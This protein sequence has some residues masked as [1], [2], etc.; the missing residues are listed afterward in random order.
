MKNRYSKQFIIKKRFACL[1]LAAGI[2]GCAA[3]GIDEAALPVF[4][5]VS[6]EELSAVLSAVSQEV[7]AA[8]LPAVSQEETVSVPLMVLQDT[9]ASISSAALRMEEPVSVLP[10]ALQMEEPVSVLSAALRMEEPA[11]V[12]LAASRKEEPASVSSAALRMEE[13][14]SVLPAA[15]Q[16]EDAPSMGSVPYFRDDA[17]LNTQMADGYLY[18]YWD[19]RLCRYDP[20]TLEETVLF[21]AR[22]PQ[23]GDF[24][25]WGD[26]IYFMVVPRVSSVGWIHGQ[27]YRVKCDGSE[28]AVCLTSVKMPTEDHIKAD[29]GNF[30]LDT[31]DDIL[32]LMACFGN[33]TAENLYF[34]LGPDGSLSRA[35]EEE[36]LYGLLPEGYYISR[37]SH[38]YLSPPYAMRNYGYLFASGPDGR[39]VRIDPDSQAIEKISALNYIWNGYFTHDAIFTKEGKCWGRI[40]LDQVDRMRE[41]GESPEW[42]NFISWDDAGIYLL[43]IS[44]MDEKGEADLLFMDRDGEVTTLRSGLEY[45]RGSR[46]NYF[47]GKYFY[48]TIPA[49][50]GNMVVRLEVRGKEPPETVAYY[51]RDPYY[52]MTRKETLVYNWKDNTVGYGVECEIGKVYFTE[53]TEGMGKINAFLDGLYAEEIAAADGHRARMKENEET[54]LEWGEAVTKLSGTANVCY[55]DENYV[56]VCLEQYEHS[57]LIRGERKY[58][59]YVFDRGTGERLQITD[60]VNDSPEAVCGVIVP[61]I[62]NIAPEGTGEEGWESVILEQDRFFLTEEGV[63]I[64]FDRGELKSNPPDVVWDIVVPYSAFAL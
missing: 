61:Y 30:V 22:A 13:P 36:T 28:E 29:W 12:L 44:Q 53:E 11:S 2:G 48:Y 4:P 49:E 20:E 6:Q 34:H 14:V 64:H 35:A 42:C 58:L 43:R 1:C 46:V 3:C 25:I 19:R 32:Y 18:G 37:S 31:Y 7:P 55:M 60:V 51:N 26:Y 33:S 17:G 45:G 39:P 52:D 27:L 62:E 50:D 21:E 38:R 23:N 56:C 9:S 10:A 24:C 59:Y 54:Y 41:T 63:G 40:S 47:D 15:S 8:V 5:A 16:A 57:D